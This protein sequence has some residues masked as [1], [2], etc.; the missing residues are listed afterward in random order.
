MVFASCLYVTHLTSQHRIK[1][2][3]LFSNKLSRCSVQRRRVMTTLLMIP[4]GPQIIFF[5]LHENIL[6]FEGVSLTCRIVDLKLSNDYC[7]M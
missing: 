3:S 7:E 2:G 4:L 1:Y 5:V 6:C